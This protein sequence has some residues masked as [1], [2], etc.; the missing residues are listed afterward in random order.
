VLERV[1]DVSVRADQNL[2]TDASGFNARYT[3]EITLVT[4]DGTCYERRVDVPKGFPDNPMTPGEI[5]AKFRDQAGAVLDDSAVEATIDFV[6][7]IDSEEDVSR[8]LDILG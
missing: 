8:L 5:E 7:N 6:T 4:R 3:T 2:V 1:E